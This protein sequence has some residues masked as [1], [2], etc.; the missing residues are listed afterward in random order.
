[1]RRPFCPS[2]FSNESW[3]VSHSTCICTA[4]TQP[5]LSLARCYWRTSNGEFKKKLTLKKGQMASVCTRSHN[6]SRTLHKH[7][8]CRLQSILPCPSAIPMSN[9]DLLLFS[10]W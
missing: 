4:K 8:T 1:L 9:M 10:P 3:T 6:L 7:T 2:S 5:R